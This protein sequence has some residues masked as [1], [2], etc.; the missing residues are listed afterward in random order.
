MTTIIIIIIGTV[1]GTQGIVWGVNV[2]WNYKMVKE[3]KG[4][5]IGYITKEDWKKGWWNIW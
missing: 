2:I 1:I 5:M 3:N 4:W